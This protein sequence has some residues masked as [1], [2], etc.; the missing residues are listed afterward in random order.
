MIRL[1]STPWG[2]MLAWTLPYLPARVQRIALGKMYGG[3]DRVLD[4]CL[5]EIVH[6]L[7]NP[8]TLRHVL[9][10]LRCWFTEM[11]KLGFALRRIRRKPVLLIWGDHDAT[12]SLR[13]GAKLHRKLRSDLVVVPGCG[14]SVFE[15]M[16]EQ[17]N[18]IVLDWLAKHPLAPVAAA[19]SS[20]QKAPIESLGSSSGLQPAVTKPLK[21]TGL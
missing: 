9:C 20:S 11:P 4:R 1:Y 3:T 8:G 16:P 13:S 18:Q 19:A 21:A 14:H 2:G 15:E 7:R 6:C 5:D 12:V 17:A 10:I